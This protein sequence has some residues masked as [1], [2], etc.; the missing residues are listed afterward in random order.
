MKGGKAGRPRPMHAPADAAKAKRGPSR[1]DPKRKDWGP[2][3]KDELPPP[4][5]APPRRTA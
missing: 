2:S 4:P 3:E 1:G 5:P